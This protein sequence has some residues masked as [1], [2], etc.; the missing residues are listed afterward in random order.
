V[1]AASTASLLY[2]GRALFAEVETRG[3]FGSGDPIE[4]ANLVSG[5]GPFDSL[6]A[7]VACVAS[8]GV[9]GLSWKQC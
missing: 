2:L 9:V 7:A 8:M 3:Y 6:D 1:F 5:A 4:A